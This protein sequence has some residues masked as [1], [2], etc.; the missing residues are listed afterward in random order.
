MGRAT[1][2]PRAAQEGASLAAHRARERQGVC[3]EL[4]WWLE[5]RSAE[6]LGEAWPGQQDLPQTERGLKE[7]PPRDRLEPL[8]L[9]VVKAAQK[10]SSVL[11]SRTG[12]RAGFTG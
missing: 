8:L 2:A 4:G 11:A 3:E 6:L 12:F 10:L 7:P 5:H 1:A 9:W